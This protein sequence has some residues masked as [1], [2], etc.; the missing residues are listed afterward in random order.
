MSLPNIWEWRI[1]LAYPG[2]G[3]VL[4]TEHDRTEHDHS[5]AFGHY[6]VVQNWKSPMREIIEKALSGFEFLEELA[7]RNKEIA[8]K[9]ARPWIGYLYGSA[10]DN[11]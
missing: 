11:L 3:N 6:P 4:I 8:A 7:D 10:R 9:L 5:F 2:P 1:P